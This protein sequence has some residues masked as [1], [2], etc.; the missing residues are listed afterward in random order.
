MVD[1]R[2]IEENNL[3]ER[4]VL[5]RLPTEEQVRFEEH[6]AD[7]EACIAELELADDLGTALRTVVAEDAH[8][9]MGVMAVL[10]RWLQGGRT[11]ALRSVMAAAL[12]AGLLLPTLWLLRENRRLTSDLVALRQPQADTPSFLLSLSRDAAGAPVPELPIAES[13]PWMTLDIE[14]DDPV[15]VGYDVT[16]TDADGSVRWQQEGLEPNLW[17]VLQLTF[18]TDLLPPGDYHLQLEGKDAGGRGE[19]VG[20]YPFRV[21]RP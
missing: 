7:C 18:P 3:I 4:Y 14:A 15:F 5:G 11:P 17:S 9:T 13:E 20:T 8:R 1:H 21:T 2:Y 6:F 12:V 10:A 16:L 19:P